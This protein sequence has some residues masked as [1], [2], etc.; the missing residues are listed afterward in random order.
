[1]SHQPNSTL[2]AETSAA[3][4]ASGA[5]PPAL[6]AP[7]SAGEDTAMIMHAAAPGQNHGNGGGFHHH[8]GG[9]HGHH[10][11]ENGQVMMGA[12][13]S[14][15]RIAPRSGSMGHLP[16]MDHQGERY[17]P[18]ATRAAKRQFICFQNP[19]ACRSAKRRSPFPGGFLS[20]SLS[21]AALNQPP[22]QPCGPPHHMHH[23]HLIPGSVNSTPGGGWMQPAS[24]GD[25][26]LSK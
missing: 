5:N 22:P 3:T 14:P 13:G 16:R 8:H 18:T 23:P 12:M 2:T 1:M 7:P 10:G 24:G 25:E 4:P 19:T 11:F 20:T 9:G 21:S 17:T 6:G 15:Y 26:I